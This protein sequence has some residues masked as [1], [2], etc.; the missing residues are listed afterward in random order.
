MEYLDEVCIRFP[1]KTI[2]THNGNDAI[3]PFKFNLDMVQDT[4]ECTTDV[5]IKNKLYLW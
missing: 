3:N 1:L 4:L 2:Q 5:Q